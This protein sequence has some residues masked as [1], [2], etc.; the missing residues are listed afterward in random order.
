MKTPK[1]QVKLKKKLLTEKTI[2]FDLKLVVYLDEDCK[3]DPG[4]IFCEAT[5]LMQNTLNDE[6][7]GGA[8]N[9]HC[10]LTW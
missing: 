1:I 8:G 7:P 4:D 6:F 5:G 10:E 9:P 2:T 3:E